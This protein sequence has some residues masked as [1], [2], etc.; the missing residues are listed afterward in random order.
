M[1]DT[2]D[3]IYM[4][5]VLELAKL[6]PIQTRPNPQ[7]AAIVVKYNEIIGIGCHLKSGQHH[8]EVH[9]LNQAGKNA[10]NATLYVNLEPCS[11]FGATPPCTDAIIASKIKKVVI[12]NLDQ[13]PLVSGT[14]V[15]KLRAAGIEVITEILSKEATEI[16]QIFFHNIIAKKPYVTLK[17]GMSLDAKIS[18]KQNISQWI[19]S[20][21]SR[22]DAH[23]YRINHEAILVGVGTVISDNPSLTAH[24]IKNTSKNPIRVILDSRLETPLDSKVV[25]DNISPTWIFTM[26]KE[27]S[28]H[29]KYI[30]NGCKI[31]VVESMDLDHILDLLYQNN[32]YTLLIEGGERVYGEFLDKKLVNQIISYVSPQLIG[33]KDAKHLY[34]GAGFTNLVDNLKLEF[35][36]CKQIGNDIKIVAKVIN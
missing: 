25:V 14:G 9:A 34:A 11:H 22:V 23:Q 21:E 18:T 2:N 26:N 5:K 20:S 27:T 12:A 33:S 28:I 36:E 7:V 13:N 3:I 31:L 6:T 35:T 17:V 16:N 15:N 8:A 30:K 1:L 10:E 24:L 29:Q 19:T 4:Q 32:I